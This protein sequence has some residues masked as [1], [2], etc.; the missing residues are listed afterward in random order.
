M[1]DPQFDAFQVVFDNL[2][3]NWITY[4]IN[5]DIIGQLPAGSSKPF[6]GKPQDGHCVLENLCVLKCYCA[7]EGTESACRRFVAFA[8]LRSTWLTN[9]PFDDL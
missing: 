4:Q 5:R 6:F 7:L 8:L 3:P 9:D 2:K 1:I